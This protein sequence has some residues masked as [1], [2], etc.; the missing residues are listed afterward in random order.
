LY[1]VIDI[2][3]TGGNHH[4][5]KIIE[6][7][8][9]KTDGYKII[10][11]YETLVNPEVKI[12]SFIT[13]LTGINDAMVKDAPKFFEVAKEIVLF[14]E[15][16]FFVAHNVGFDFG[17]IKEELSNLGFTYKREQ[18]CTVDLTRALLPGHDSYSLG[19]LS[20]DLGIEINGRHRA[21]G[22]AFAT[23]TI[24]Q[25]LFEKYDVDTIHKFIKKPKAPYLP[26]NLTESLVEALPKEMGVYHFLNDKHEIIYIGKSINIKNRV[27]SHFKAKASSKR[28]MMMKQIHDVS[29]YLI[30]SEL[31]ALITE[32]IEI[33]QY[34]PTFNKLLRV[35]R[36]G[37]GLFVREE[38]GYI[39]L[40]IKKL[41]GRT[42]PF[43]KFEN[44]KKANAFLERFTTKY[45]LCPTINGIGNSKEG[46][47]CFA[48][49]IDKCDGACVEKEAIN[50]YNDKVVKA[51][52]TY[53][54]PTNNVM[55]VDLH[56][57][58]VYT[59]YIVQKGL[60]KGWFVSDKAYFNEPEEVMRQMVK[61]PRNQDVQLVAKSFIKSGRGSKMRRI[62]FKI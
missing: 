51:L 25:Q 5:G 61:S 45:R 13:G 14:T 26:P 41:T 15:G 19:K 6:V 53:S 58:K 40:E 37:Y 1:C 48:H 24:F 4:T 36:Y 46:T 2:E 32:A 55:F 59:Y 7:A 50:T 57:P 20:K 3:T 8:M 43:L 18:L 44:I 23:V 33:K 22:D 27:K 42:K 38:L 49:Q 9:Y 11:S 54:L 12:D 56:N 10:D 62:D 35:K 34:K 39:R 52:N 28:K 47:P 29:Y 17:F 30:D 21:A 31:L 60:L 16:C